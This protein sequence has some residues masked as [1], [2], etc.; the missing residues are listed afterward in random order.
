MKTGDRRSVLAL[1][2][3]ACVTVAGSAAVA[4]EHRRSPPLYSKQYFERLD[5]YQS[6]Y[7]EEIFEFCAEIYLEKIRKLKRC[8]RDQLEFKK[9]ILAR[10]RQQTGTKTLARVIYD[11]CLEFH[12]ANG[13]GRIGACVDTRLILFDRVRDI[14]VERAIYRKCESK[15]RSSGAPAIDVCCA[16]EGS[17]YQKYGEMRD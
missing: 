15:W 16:H 12:P 1:V 17:Y 8:L 10:A 2:L 13:V 7:P 3:V 6:V 14:A 4:D 11:D 5:Y 9:K